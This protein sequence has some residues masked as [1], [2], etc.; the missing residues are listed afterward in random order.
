MSAVSQRLSRAIRYHGFTLIELLVVIAIIGILASVVLA[1]LSDARSSARDSAWLSEIRS[2]QTALEIFF[3]E[4]GHYPCPKN[5][6]AHNCLA[7]T[8][9]D[10]IRIN[11][12]DTHSQSNAVNLAVRDNFLADIAEYIDFPVVDP[13]LSDSGGSVMYKT[14]ADRRDYVL[15]ARF[16]NSPNFCVI[17]STGDNPFSGN[18]WW[19]TGLACS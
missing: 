17:A 2:L 9:I 10:D 12:S 11:T 8:N 6:S 18:Q 19:D 5:T 15:R 16:E 1:S 3:V 14:T 13:Q 4:H 7:T